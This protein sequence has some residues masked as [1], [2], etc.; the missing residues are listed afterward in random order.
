MKKGNKAI[1]NLKPPKDKIIILYNILA[2]LIVLIPEW[3]AEVTIT[4]ENTFRST[5]IRE[6]DNIWETKSELRLSSMSLKELRLLALEL[7]LKGYARESKESLSLRLLKK[8]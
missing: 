5:Q 6:L 4:I 7:N 3:I 2:I 8:L 1:N